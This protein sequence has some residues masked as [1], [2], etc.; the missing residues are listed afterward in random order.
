MDMLNEGLFDCFCIVS[1]DS[2]FT[3]LVQ[4]IKEKG[5]TVVGLGEKKSIDAFVKACN[6]FIYLDEKSL[7]DD[8]LDESS[9]D[10]AKS[11]ADSINALMNKAIKNLQDQEGKVQMNAIVPYLKQIR[12]D[13]DLSSYKTDDGNTIG[14]LSTYF[15]GHSKYALN[16]DNTVVWKK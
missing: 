14:K 9:A 6:D 16:K 12:P 7:H 13:F 2:D 4:K 5:K 1:S 8:V 11:K 10:S 15:K 3:R